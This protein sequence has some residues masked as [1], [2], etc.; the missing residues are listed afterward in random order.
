M[1]GQ[2]F[3][4]WTVLREGEAAYS[5]CGTRLRRML[6]QCNCGKEKL[7][8]LAH[9]RRGSSRSCGCL[10]KDRMSSRSASWGMKTLVGGFLGWTTEFLNFIPVGDTYALVDDDDFPALSQKNWYLKQGESGIYYAHT[11]L[12]NNKKGGYIH[13]H[14]LLL[15]LPRGYE[16]DHKNRNGL[17]NRRENLRPTTRSQNHANQ[18]TSQ[19]GKRH[20]R[21]KGVSKCG[22]KWQAYIAINGKKCHLGTFADEQGAATAYN[23]AAKRLFG[24]FA[25]VNQL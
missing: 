10:Y 24:E 11:A 8:R 23:E 14:Q 6:C 19:T 1:I 22:C 20:S 13:M 5:P 12:Q 17:D 16:V 21:Y 2:K 7:V 18:R 15:A 9:L 4:R 25:R 3:G